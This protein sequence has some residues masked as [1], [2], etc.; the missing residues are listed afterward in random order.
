MSEVLGILFLTIVVPIW[1]VAHYMTKWKTA[2]GLSTDDEQLL[3]E[4]WRVAQKMEN[5][6]EA[7]ETIL[8]ANTERGEVRDR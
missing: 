4:L 8:D 3:E 6:V 2:K 1:L 7:L 5:R